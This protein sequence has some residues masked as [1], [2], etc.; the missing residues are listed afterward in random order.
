MKKIF[1]TMVAAFMAVTLASCG[2]AAP[3]PVEVSD[4]MTDDERADLLTQQYFSDVQITGYTFGDKV[5][6]VNEVREV[7]KPAVESCLDD[8]AFQDL[9]SRGYKVN[10]VGHGCMY[11]GSAANIQM[12][13]QR[14]QQVVYEL[15]AMG[16]DVSMV[17]VKSVG[18]TLPREDI[19]QG[20]PGQRR[21]TVEVSSR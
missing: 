18:D 11:G 17:G 7:V 16:V 10:V 12:G 9:S 19:S 2:G 5:A 14:A 4:T 21:V 15:R 20:R 13:R 1:L 8:P 6:S 3:E